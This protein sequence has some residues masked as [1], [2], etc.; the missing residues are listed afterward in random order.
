LDHRVE[1]L[2]PEEHVVRVAIPALSIRKRHVHV[3][4]TACA[5]TEVGRLA[6]IGVEKTGG[7][8][9]PVYGHVHHLLRLVKDLLNGGE[10]IGN[11]SG[12]NGGEIKSGAMKEEERQTKSAVKRGVKT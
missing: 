9:V 8:L 1:Q 5:L 10:K 2:L 12:V 3:K 4:P 7:V 11:A 6:S